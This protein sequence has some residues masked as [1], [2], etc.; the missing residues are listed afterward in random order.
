MLKNWKKVSCLLERSSQRLLFNQL[1]CTI[2]CSHNF[3]QL[4][5][6]I[7]LKSSKQPLSCE[8]EII[9]K[10]IHFSPVW[11]IRSQSWNQSS[12]AFIWDTT[13]VQPAE[14]KQY[15]HVRLPKFHQWKGPKRVNRLR[16]ATSTNACTHA[17]NFTSHRCLKLVPTLQTSFYSYK[18]PF[19]FL[20]KP[21]QITTSDYGI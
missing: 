19:V 6:F 17:C 15:T 5:T 7:I 11:G 18:P 4:V 3:Q 13:R 9:S 20:S 16:Y 1:K 14:T 8:S 12:T 10:H 2:K 21:A